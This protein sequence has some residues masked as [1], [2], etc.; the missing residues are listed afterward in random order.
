[1][2]RLTALALCVLFLLVTG[3]GTLFAEPRLLKVM[4][5]PFIPDANGDNFA[6]LV[7]D[8]ENLFAQENPDIDLQIT[9]DTVNTDVTNTYDTGVLDTVFGTGDG[10]YQV[11]EVDMLMLNYMVSHDYLVPIA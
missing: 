2:M 4:L 6:Q 11:V 10:A 3:C 1:M 9:M 5:Y 7:S 8:L